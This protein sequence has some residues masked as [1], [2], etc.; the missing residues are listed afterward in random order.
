VG[1]E[2]GFSTGDIKITDRTQK[3]KKDVQNK[4]K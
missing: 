3:K 1:E 4:E 2:N